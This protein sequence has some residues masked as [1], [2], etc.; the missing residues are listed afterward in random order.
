MTGYPSLWNWTLLADVF[1]QLV[2]VQNVDWDSEKAIPKDI[3]TTLEERNPSSKLH[4]TL[5]FLNWDPYDHRVSGPRPSGYEP[6]HQNRSDAREA[7]VELKVLY[8][9][10]AS[11]RYGGC[12]SLRDMD[13][14][15]HILSSC[16]NLRCT[17]VSWPLRLCNE[18]WS[19]VRL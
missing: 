12:P 9:L 6:N 10:K 15:F 18:R 16:T 19:A 3:L 11:V 13:L 2:G 8:A 4:Y 1:E 14:I 17:L 5:S 7:I